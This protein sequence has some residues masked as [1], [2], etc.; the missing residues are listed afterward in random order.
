MGSLQE[1]IAELKSELASS[2]VERASMADGLGAQ[3][4]AAEEER[5]R[6]HA[7]NEV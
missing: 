7:E 2:Q 1:A 3:L 5:L 6:L 4:A